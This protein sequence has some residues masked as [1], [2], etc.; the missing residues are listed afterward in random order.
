MAIVLHAHTIHHVITISYVVI[1]IAHEGI[2]LTLCRAVLVI[3][4][5]DELLLGIACTQRKA[6]GI[7]PIGIVSC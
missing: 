4:R 7:F 5:D 6:M 3:Q 2:K 1:G